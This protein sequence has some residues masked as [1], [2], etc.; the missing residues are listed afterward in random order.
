MVD[1][2]AVAHVYLS[3]HVRRIGEGHED[4]LKTAVVKE[5]QEST[6]NVLKS[7]SAP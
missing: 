1:R 4:T 7:L 2:D 5:H 6:K 3:R